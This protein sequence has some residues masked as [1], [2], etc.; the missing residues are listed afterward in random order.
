[1]KIAK[2]YTSDIFIKNLGF[3]ESRRL[4]L[5]KC[6]SDWILSLDADEEIPDKLAKEIQTAIKN[7]YY[8]A[9]KI[10]NRIL[11]LSGWT[12]YPIAHS[13]DTKLVRKNKAV[14]VD[15][16]VGEHYEATGRIGKLNNYYIHRQNNSVSD[17]VIKKLDRYTTLQ[18]EMK[19]NNGDKFSFIKLVYVTMRYFIW[20]YI[21]LGQIRFGTRGLFQAMM[22]ANFAFL[23]EIK[24]YEKNK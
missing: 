23:S 3:G 2:E 1:M 10:P 21:L 5:K 17:Y 20:E 18:A 4:A 12:E 14:L 22:K 15:T 19:F 24:L 6:S 8:D 16:K 7:N 11:V 13:P 9:Y